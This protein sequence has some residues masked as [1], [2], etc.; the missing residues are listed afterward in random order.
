MLLG[1]LGSSL[2]GNMFAGRGINKAGAGI[3]RA[4]YGSERSSIK[5]KFKFHFIL[6]LI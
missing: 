2:L 1:T 3:M 6:Q 4:V 5:I